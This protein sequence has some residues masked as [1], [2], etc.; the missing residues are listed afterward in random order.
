MAAPRNDNIKGRIL[1]AAESLLSS[2]KMS[3]MTLTD[4]AREA[5]ISKGTIYY[6][7]K[8]KNDIL[9][10]VTDMYLDRQYNK[11]IE[12]TEDA[13]KDTSL[14]RLIKFVLLGDIETASTRLGLFHDAAAGNEALRAR[15]LERYS[16]F[17][18]ILASKIAERSEGIPSD[19]LAWLL[20]LLS[21]G[22]CMHQSIDDPQI[23]V[24]AFIANSE[25]YLTFD[26]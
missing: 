8:S 20:L 12:W 13:S 9:F 11:L 7:Y 21:D 19:Y 6:Y 4:I 14:H 25:R 23:D 26:K 10:D 1:E 15:V 24:D 16:N 2:G 18:S 5:G 22:I 3:D 17:A